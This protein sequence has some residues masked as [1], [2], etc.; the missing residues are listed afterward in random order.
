[1]VE[2]IDVVKYMSSVQERI[3]ETKTDQMILRH[4]SQILLCDFLQEYDREEIT[5]ESAYIFMKRN[6]QCI[7]ALALAINDYCIKCVDGIDQLE[8]ICNIICDE[9]EC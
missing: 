4:L 1:M 9:L 3:M 8:E 7:Y 6:Y 2:P 5:K